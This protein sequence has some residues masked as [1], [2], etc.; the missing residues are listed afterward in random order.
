MRDSALTALAGPLSNFI[1][2]ILLAVILKYL[3][4]YLSEEN[5][6][7][8]FLLLLIYTT[9][10][11]NISLGIFNLFPFPPLDGSKI[12]GLIVPRKWHR[13]YSN[14]LENGAKYLVVIILVDVFILGRVLGYS[15]FGT[16]MG[17]LHDRISE[18]LLL[19]T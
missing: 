8:E 10:H 16:V 13:Q 14:Y 15:V 6:L 7:H 18:I 1:L 9:F 2:A 3:S 5:A 11:V 4:K 12:L 17:Y 19:G